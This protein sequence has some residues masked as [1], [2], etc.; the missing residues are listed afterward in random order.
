MS[1]RTF[2]QRYMNVCVPSGIKLLYRAIV[3]KNTFKPNPYSRLLWE[4]ETQ[5]DQD[6][7]SYHYFK[8]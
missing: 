5:E 8:I 7:I 4:F 6:H 1:D 2:I 3:S